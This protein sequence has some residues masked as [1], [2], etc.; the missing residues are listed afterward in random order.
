M[1]FIDERRNEVSCFCLSNLL[2]LYQL[3]CGWD[4]QFFAD[5]LREVVF[6][7]HVLNSTMLA[8]TLTSLT[9]PGVI[10]MEIKTTTACSITVYLR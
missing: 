6:T 7:H 3:V 4:A 10:M 2:L 9:V 8:K 1:R 5:V